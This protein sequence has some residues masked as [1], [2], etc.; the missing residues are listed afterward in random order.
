M[1]IQSRTRS[2][3]TTVAW[4]ACIAVSLCTWVGCAKDATRAPIRVGIAVPL[5]GSG[6]VLGQ[7][8]RMG[9]GLAMIQRNAQG[10]IDGRRI[11][12][13]LGDDRADPDQ[14]VV[15]AHRFADDPT[16]LAVIGHYN[17]ACSPA[18]KPVYREA[19]VLQFSPGSTNVDVCRGSDW[20]FRNIYSDDFAGRS[21]AQYVFGALGL[22]RVGVIYDDDAYGA[23]LKTSFVDEADR[24]GLTVVGVEAYNRDAAPDYSKAVDAIH[25]L[26]PEIIMIAGLY[27]AAGLIAKDT[28]D[29]GLATP[30]IGGDAVMSEALADVGGEAVE[31]MMIAT[32]YIVDPAVGGAEAQEFAQNF[33][34]AYD[35]PADTWAALAYDAARQ[36]IDAIDEVGADRV[37]I[38][39]RF[40]QTTS[41][42]TAFQGITGATYF[43]ENGD[44]LKPAYIAVVRDG[45]FVLAEKQLGAL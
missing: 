17:S 33:Q 5:S 10:G 43:D 41:I 34:D 20:T 39:D 12:L 35:R 32:P 3:A 31:G 9:A 24:I 25:A 13:V 19:G 2:V 38:R 16:I 36:L 7:Q 37:R 26:D 23:G 4:I 42:E 28:R 27:N 8:I 15:V 30:F 11:E 21:I 18:G 6:A 45:K 14:A 44:C 1:N 22:G 40:A 29:K